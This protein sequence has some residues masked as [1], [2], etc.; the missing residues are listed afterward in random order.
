MYEKL[1]AGRG[2]FLGIKL[3][4]LLFSEILAGVSYCI[5]YKT[6]GSGHTCSK[7]RLWW[8]VGWWFSEIGSILI[9]LPS[10][11]YL[12]FFMDLPPNHFGS[13][14][15]S[16]SPVS[17]NALWA[18]C[19]E[20]IL[21]DLFTKRLV[22]PLHTCLPLSL[23][24]PAWWLKGEQVPLSRWPRLALGA[25]VLVENWGLFSG[26][27]ALHF[28]FC[29]NGVRTPASPRMSSA[30]CSGTAAFTHPGGQGAERAYSATQQ[31]TGDK[32]ALSESKQ[33]L[34]PQ[35]P[36]TWY[37]STGPQKFPS[38]PITVYSCPLKKQMPLKS[39]IVGLTK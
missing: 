22:I 33:V 5:G 16:V 6:S 35:T 36:L 1:G 19:I 38:N 31:R 9:P 32:A 27:P 28:L 18:F 25:C 15:S 14:V 11:F 4:K 7:Q 3:R 30:R 26:L 29:E 23:A 21:L 34:G 37:A 17:T 2:P 12:L 13:K 24:G 8:Q 20:P 39:S 10:K